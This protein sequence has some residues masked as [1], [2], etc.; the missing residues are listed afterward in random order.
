MN[1]N[2]CAGYNML[3]SNHLEAVKS[4]QNSDFVKRVLPEMIISAYIK[5][6]SGECL[7]KDEIT[8]LFEA[9]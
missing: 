7:P 3:P 2:D 4:A 1:E 5:R 6:I 8:G 9:M